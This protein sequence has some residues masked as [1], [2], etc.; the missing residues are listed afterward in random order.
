LSRILRVSVCYFLNG[1]V[2]AAQPEAPAYVLAGSSGW[3]VND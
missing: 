1:I 2:F 3:A